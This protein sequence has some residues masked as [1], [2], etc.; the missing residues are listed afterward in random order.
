[1]TLALYVYSVWSRLENWPIGFIFF[2]NGKI[3]KYYTNALISHHFELNCMKWCIEMKLCV[4]KRKLKWN[5][6]SDLWISIFTLYYIFVSYIH[7]TWFIMPIF[8][9]IK[10]I[11]F[12]YIFPLVKHIDALLIFI[13]MIQYYS[14]LFFFSWKFCGFF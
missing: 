10:K 4:W 6:I 2:W 1:M 12:K 7:L 5:N 14:F 13:L 9:S 11:I 3:T 8:C